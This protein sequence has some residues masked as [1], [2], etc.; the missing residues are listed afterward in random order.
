MSADDDL[1]RLLVIILTIVLLVPLLMMVFAWP[2]MG[3]WGGGHM[4]DGTGATWWPLMWLVFLVLLTGGG[5]LLY[6]ASTR[7]DGRETDTALD[8]LRTAYARGDL[9]DEEFEQRRQRLLPPD[10]E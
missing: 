1:V 7:S 3:M 6:R 8:E 4:W 2:M 5:Y 10:E 9:S